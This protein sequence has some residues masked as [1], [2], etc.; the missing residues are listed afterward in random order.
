MGGEGDGRG[1]D[2]IYRMG[3]GDGWDGENIEQRTRNT[4]R[5]RT[6]TDNAGNIIADEHG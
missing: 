3:T 5:T 2:R 6:V 4:E 1:V